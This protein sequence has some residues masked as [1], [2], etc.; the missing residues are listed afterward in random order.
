MRES[1]GGEY[2]GFQAPS[3]T[4]WAS[5]GSP[6]PQPGTAKLCLRTSLNGLPRLTF[7]ITILL[8]LLIGSVCLFWLLL[9]NTYPPGI[10]HTPLWMMGCMRPL[11]WWGW[12]PPPWWGWERKACGSMCIGT[13]P[14]LGRGVHFSNPGIWKDMKALSLIQFNSI[15]I[16]FEFTNLNLQYHSACPL[17]TIAGQ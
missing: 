7:R 15:Q 16:E 12:H 2:S 4:S 9:F 1:T 8:V 11:P 5:L 17:F 10:P 6:S 3:Q 14:S 13:W